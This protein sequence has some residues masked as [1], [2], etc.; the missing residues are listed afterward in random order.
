MNIEAI[1]QAEGL[2]LTDTGETLVIDTWLDSEGDECTAQD[3]PAAFVVQMPNGK[4]VGALV[5]NYEPAT[6]Q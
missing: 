4:W 3:N 6:I 5:A 1:N 2:V